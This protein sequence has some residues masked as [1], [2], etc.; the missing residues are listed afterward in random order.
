MQ[1]L[2]AA[3][4][5]W[6]GQNQP[7]GAKAQLRGRHTSYQAKTTAQLKLVQWESASREALDPFRPSK[8]ELVSRCQQHRK[9]ELRSY[10]SKVGSHFCKKAE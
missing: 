9:G 6:L 5:Q 7:E 3:H 2:G 10:R 1:G 4:V 8:A